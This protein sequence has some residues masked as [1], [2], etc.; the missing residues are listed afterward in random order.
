MAR[1]RREK[2]VP[3][4]RGPDALVVVCSDHGFHSPEAG[5]TEDP[6]ELAGPAAA[7]HRPY[8]IVAAAEAGVIAGRLPGRPVDAGVV[9]PLDIAPT[10]LHAAGLPVPLEMTGRVVAALLP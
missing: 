2:I 1:R 5:V 6:A 4:V 9:S 10:V 8:G 7:W 3:P